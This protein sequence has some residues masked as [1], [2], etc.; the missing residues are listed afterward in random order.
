MSPGT[1][2][3]SLQV[4]NICFKLDAAYTNCGGELCI[5][6]KLFLTSAPWHIGVL[7]KVYR[8]VIGV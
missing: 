1:Q 7:Q 6:K 8:C 5:L 4:A 3:D 2:R